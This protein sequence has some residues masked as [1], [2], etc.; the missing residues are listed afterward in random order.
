MRGKTARIG[1]RERG[2]AAGREDPQAAPI[3]ADERESMAI[4]IRHRI[5]AAK[6]HG[7]VLAV[8]R[9][10]EFGFAPGDVMG[11]AE[12]AQGD[13]V[14]RRDGARRRRDRGRGRQACRAIARGGRGGGEQGRA[15]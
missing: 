4:A 1:Q 9:D 8:G 11:D 2:L 6:Q 14:A 15:R 10:R 5:G 12:V 7:D 13:E 3:G